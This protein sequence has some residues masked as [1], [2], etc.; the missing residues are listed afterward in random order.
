[1]T[2]AEFVAGDF[3]GDVELAA[4]ADL[5]DGGGFSFWVDA[6][7]EIGNER[8]GILCGGEADALWR[9]GEAGEKLAGA[10][11][12]F[13]GHEGV[14]AFE[15]QGEVGTALVVGDGVDFVDDDGAD[16][17]EIFPG[18]AG[19]EK[20]VERLRRGDEN[21]R[22]VAKHGGTLFGEGVAGADAGADFRAEIAALH[23][24]AL[25]FG[26]WGVEVFLYVVGE[27]FER[28]DIDDLGAGRELAGEGRAEELIDADQECG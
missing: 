22:R 25:N 13:A 10:E 11:A 9:C 6:G 3:D 23:G 24:E 8:D 7:E 21:V 2:E 18:F 12:V 4:L 27:G 19:G 16:A 15:R 28:A 17:A 14:E 5:D 1:M 20:D 26:E